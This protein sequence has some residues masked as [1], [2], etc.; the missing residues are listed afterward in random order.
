MVNSVVNPLESP[1]LSGKTAAA[2]P[3]QIRH[4]RFDSD[5]SLLL[6]NSRKPRGFSGLFAFSGSRFS[7]GSVSLQTAEIASLCPSEPF[8]A[9]CLGTS[10]GTLSPLPWV[11][12]AR[13]VAD[14]WGLVFG[15][16][17]S[18]SP[19]PSTRS[20]TSWSVARE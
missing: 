19:R 7:L 14:S 20:A 13:M 16:P 6:F 12:V 18:M 9:D 4:R 10:L 5:R 1:P 11:P 15:L 17:V 2:F 8:G 3:L